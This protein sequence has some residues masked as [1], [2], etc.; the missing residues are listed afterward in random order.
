MNFKEIGIYAAIIIVALSGWLGLSGEWNEFWPIFGAANQLIA[1]LTLIVLTSWFLSRSKYIR[2]TLVP[3][4]FMLV[5][6]TGAL[7]FKIREYVAKDQTVLMSIAVVLLLL[8][9]FVLYEAVRH[10]RKRYA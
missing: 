8:A 2:Y 4:I 3:A 7:V 5:T 9:L 1:A 10:V 6:T